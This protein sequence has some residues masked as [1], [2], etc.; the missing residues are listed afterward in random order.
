MGE[1]N[2]YSKLNMCAASHY[3]EGRGQRL[4]V[5]VTACQ[6]SK[7]RNSTARCFKKCIASFLFVFV[8]FIEHL[9]YVIL[10]F[11]S[12]KHKKLSA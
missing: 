6:N 11:H 4:H 9:F 12:R 7:R 3:D 8:S 2:I 10:P 5:E 1:I